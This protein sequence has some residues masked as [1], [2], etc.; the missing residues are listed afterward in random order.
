MGHYGKKAEK[1]KEKKRCRELDEE[2][3]GMEMIKIKRKK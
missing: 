1:R 2:K 3:E